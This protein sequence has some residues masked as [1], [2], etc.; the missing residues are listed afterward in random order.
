MPLSARVAPLPGAA[1][2]AP[3]GPIAKAIAAELARA[4]DIDA[5]VGRFYRDRDDRAIW[6][7]G[8]RL[9]PEA[10]TLVERVHAARGDGLDPQAYGGAA[11]AEAVARAGSGQPDDLARAEVAL[12]AAL[13]RWGRDL[14]TPATDV[15][16]IYADPAVAP[17]QVDELGV[18]QLAARTSP[19]AAIARLAHMNPL[20]EQL[21]AALAA[22]RARGGSASGA[23]TIL[24]NLERA[25]ALPPDLGRRYVLVDAAAQKLWLYEDGRPADSM[26]VVVGKL[27]EPT[28]AMAGLIRFAVAHP[29]W[30]VPPDLVRDSIAPKVLRYGTSYLASQNM[31]VL[32]DWTPNATVL[33]PASVDWR[34]VASGARILRVRQRPG[35]G[36]MMGQVKFVFPNQLGVY[37]HD[38]PLRQFFAQARRTE[39]AGCVRLADAPRLARW[40]LGDDARLLTEPGEPEE[41]VNLPE[42]VPVYIVYLTASPGPQGLVFHPDVYRRDAKLEASLTKARSVSPAPLPAKPQKAA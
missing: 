34:A 15:G 13:A 23:R 8:W 33:P 21:R 38:T 16:M 40:L 29:Y 22:W 35:D 39:S 14:H 41:R 7:R 31:E 5:A 26:D 17:P 25:R 42:P 4:P 27:S 2:H 11:L 10:E 32:S 6:V 28:P 9:K 24:A 3:Y 1:R 30:N 18:L 19:A 12:S 37:L 20:Y 36:N